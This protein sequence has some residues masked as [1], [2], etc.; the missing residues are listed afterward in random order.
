MDLKLLDVLLLKDGR[1]GTVLEVFE[2]GKGFMVEIAD[3]DGATIEMPIIS[4]DEI[5]K[6]TYKA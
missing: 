2:E 4:A 3:K 5:D 1:E 6:I